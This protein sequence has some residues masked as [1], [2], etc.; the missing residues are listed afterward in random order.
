MKMLLYTKVVIS[1]GNIKV[2]LIK[3]LCQFKDPTCQSI[4]NFLTNQ[5]A[6]D[7]IIFVITPYGPT[8]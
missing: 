4:S 1:K 7:E 3:E 2:M 5:I 8:H 6:D